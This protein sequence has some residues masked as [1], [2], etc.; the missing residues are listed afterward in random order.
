[1]KH[2][3]G[4]EQRPIWKKLALEII[5]LNRFIHNYLFIGEPALGMFFTSPCVVP[6]FKSQLEET[7]ET[8]KS[9]GISGQAIS[10]CTS[11]VCCL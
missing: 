9:Y 4:L 2:Q 10:I 8:Q 3:K 6:D 5:F 1:M 7:R 11:L